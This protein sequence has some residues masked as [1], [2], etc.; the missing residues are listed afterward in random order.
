MQQDS[1]AI[2]GAVCLSEEGL[3]VLTLAL[4]VCRECLA[5]RNIRTLPYVVRQ[6]DAFL[7]NA[8]GPGAVAWVSVKESQ[9]ICSSISLLVTRHVSGRK[10]LQWL[11]DK[12]TDRCEGGTN[13]MDAAARYGHLGVVRW[14]HEHR[15]EG[16]STDSMDWAIC[17]GDV[18]MA[19]WLQA[20][21]TEG[22]TDFAMTYAGFGGHLEVLHWLSENRSEGRPRLALRA[23]AQMDA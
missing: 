22:C 21:R 12:Y 18:A 4:T 14:L 11:S 15:G 5:K 19:T 9:Y 10:L 20:N 6:I 16:C 17:R 13:V 7:D 2:G 8:S 3:P 23:A 1:T